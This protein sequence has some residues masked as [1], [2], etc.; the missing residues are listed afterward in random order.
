MAPPA[1]ATARRAATAPQQRPSTRRPPLRIFEPQPRQST[2]RRLSRRGLL[3]VA[4][5]LVLGSLLI[6][7]VADTVVAQGQVR[8]ADMQTQISGQL[9]T[10]KAMQTEVA[11][12]AAPDR[13]VAEGIAQ[14]L[15]APPQ[16]VDLP[17]VP[18][19]V[20]LPV[21]DTSPLPVAHVASPVTPVTPATPATATTARSTAAATRAAGSATTKATGTSAPT[22]LAPAR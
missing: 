22:T 20:A 18:L 11:E 14:G 21:P 2:R 6:V 5:L 8:L 7:V 15:T 17:E 16:V 12:L 19:N 13:V 9:T 1:S 10:Q 4:G 3:W